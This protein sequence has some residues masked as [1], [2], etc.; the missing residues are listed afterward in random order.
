MAATETIYELWK[1]RNNKSFGETFDIT[2]IGKRIIDI[3][4]YRGWN[5]KKLR[6]YIAILMIEEC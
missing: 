3:L 6:N 5:N 4:V 2:K 1:T